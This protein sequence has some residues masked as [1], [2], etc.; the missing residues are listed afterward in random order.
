MTS[1]KV[2]GPQKR[3]GPIRMKLSKP[4]HKQLIHYA[5]R[6]HQ[7]VVKHQTDNDLRYNFGSVKIEDYP[8]F[9]CVLLFQQKYCVMSFSKETCKIHNGMMD[10]TTSFSFILFT[11]N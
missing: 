3:S 6:L 4:F 10:H 5:D 7:F 11:S 9:C 1:Y 2:P 8:V